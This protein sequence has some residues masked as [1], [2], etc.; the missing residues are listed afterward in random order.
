MEVTPSSATIYVEWQMYL[1]PDSSSTYAFALST[2][3]NFR[4]KATRVKRKN[5]LDFIIA[6]FLSY[7]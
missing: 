4:V 5:N 6:Y 2:E 7:S 1:T 3:F